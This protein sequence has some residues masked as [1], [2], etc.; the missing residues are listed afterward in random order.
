PC[1]T[2]SVGW[3]RSPAATSPA[4]STP[5]SSTSPWSACA[6][7]AWAETPGGRALSRPSPSGSR[8]ARPPRPK[9]LG[10]GATEGEDQAG[11]ARVDDAD[12]DPPVL[13]VHAAGSTLASLGVAGGRAGGDV[14]DALSHDGVQLQNAAQ[15]G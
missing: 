15:F 6:S 2:G 3:R 8:Q 13:L 11:A 5:P 4:P 9:R 10:G 12:G 1:A 14:Q 7:S